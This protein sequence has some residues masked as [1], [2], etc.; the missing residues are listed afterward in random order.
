[1]TFKRAVKEAKKI[2]EEGPQVAAVLK[3]W[4]SGY[5][6]YRAVPGYIDRDAE[7][8]QQIA[9]ITPDGR[10]WVRETED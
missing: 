5:S 2:A 1:M 10:V 8:L 4:G 7:E 9:L 6:E 3:I